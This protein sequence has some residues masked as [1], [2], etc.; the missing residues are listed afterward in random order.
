VLTR[1]VL[2]LFILF[3]LAARCETNDKEKTQSIADAEALITDLTSAIEEGTANSARLNTEIKNLEA[4]IGKFYG[5]TGMPVA[6][7]EKQHELARS[8]SRTPR[9]VLCVAS[10]AQAEIAKNQEALDKATVQ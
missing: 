10:I 3:F 8:G 7:M 5:S 6:P 2:R 4:G 1:A 9:V